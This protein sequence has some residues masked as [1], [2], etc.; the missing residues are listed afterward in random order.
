[1]QACKKAGEMKSGPDKY[2]K[3]IDVC[4]VLAVAQEQLSPQ[5]GDFTLKTKIESCAQI[6]KE[7]DGKILRC[8]AVVMYGKAMGKP[9]PNEPKDGAND[10][11]S[12]AAK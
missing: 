5:T 11:N 9:I 4:G 6:Y 3:I 10:P 2:N 8:K 12:P 7:D 1:M